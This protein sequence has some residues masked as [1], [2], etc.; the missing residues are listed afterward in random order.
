MCPAPSSS[1]PCIDTHPIRAVLFRLLPIRSPLHQVGLLFSNRPNHQNLHRPPPDRTGIRA[2]AL[3]SQLP[4]LPFVHSHP[5]DVSTTVSHFF[6]R[7]ECVVCLV[8]IPRRRARAFL[9]TWTPSTARFRLCFVRVAACFVSCVSPALIPRTAA[10]AARLS[11]ALAMATCARTCGSNPTKWCNSCR[12]PLP[13]PT[14]F[15]PGSKGEPPFQAS[16]SNAKPTGRRRCHHR[17]SRWW[18][19]GKRSCL[20]TKKSMQK[21]EVPY[22]I[23]RN[24]QVPTAVFSQVSRWRN[25]PTRQQAF[26]RLSHESLLTLQWSP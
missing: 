16:L 7:T 1:A 20:L 21:D 19:E 3:S 24:Q 2:R 23:M 13:S 11:A 10:P 17:R 4:R 5:T 9:G 6:F 26:A 15:D 12:W 18:W 22:T 8:H 25:S 14:G